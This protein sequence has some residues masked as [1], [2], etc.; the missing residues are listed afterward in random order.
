MWDW[1]GDCVCATPK[2]DFIVVSAEEPGDGS[3]KSEL[4]HHRSL[5]RL[6]PW[7]KILAILGKCDVWVRMYTPVHCTPQWP[8][9]SATIR[10]RSGPSEVVKVTVTITVRIVYRCQS[11]LRSPILVSARGG[12]IGHAGVLKEETLQMAE[13]PNGS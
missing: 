1:G 2:G 8:F 11:L 4:E 13:L 12:K 5:A 10:S 7:R 9:R 6:Y 3:R